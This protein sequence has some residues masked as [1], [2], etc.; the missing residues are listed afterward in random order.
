[1]EEC[2]PGNS[3]EEDEMGHTDYRTLIDRGRKAGLNAAEL[4]RAIAARQPEGGEQ[5][6]GQADC[7]GFVMG[8]N[9]AGQRVYRP[10]GSYPRP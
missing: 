9:Q 7:N 4:Y 3:T 6:V 1:V 2:E 10:L 5:A 8:Y